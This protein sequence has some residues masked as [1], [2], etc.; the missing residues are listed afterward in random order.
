MSEEVIEKGLEPVRLEEL[1]Q[2]WGIAR[3]QALDG[4]RV[5][6]E[7]L[8]KGGMESGQ[9][10]KPR[11]KVRIVDPSKAYSSPH[12]PEPAVMFSGNSQ[13]A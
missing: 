9:G 7:N 8:A 6:E 3:R 12:R 13:N 10:L 4:C 1:V 11:L 2:L 5:I